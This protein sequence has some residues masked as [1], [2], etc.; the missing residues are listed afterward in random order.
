MK[1]VTMKHDTF[2]Q[3]NFLLFVIF[4][5][6]SFRS[7]SQTSAVNRHV[8]SQTHQTVLPQQEEAGQ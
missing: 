4:L 6:L 2:S 5:V 1:P 8:I 3:L 7:V